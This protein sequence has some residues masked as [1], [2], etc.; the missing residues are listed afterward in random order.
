V[1][2]YFIENNINGEQDSTLDVFDRFFDI[3]D[4][5]R[6]SQQL[7]INYELPIN[8]IPTFSFL[9]ASYSYTGD[10]QWQKGSDLFG[11]LTLNGETYD[12]GNS[13][14]N[15]N[16]HNINSSLDMLK[17]YRYVGLI[18]KRSSVTAEKKPFGNQRNSSSTKKFSF[19]NTVVDLLTSIKRIQINYSENNGS[20]LPGY[21]Q[22]PDFIGSFRPS[23]GYVLVAK[24]IFVI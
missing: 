11:N 20:F 3:G 2:N 17:L 8:K 12:L 24:E 15:A 4:P 19:K 23:L 9:N 10:F 21:L 14:S 7:A 16:T 6:Q 1:K 13:I 5:N 18:K 22:T